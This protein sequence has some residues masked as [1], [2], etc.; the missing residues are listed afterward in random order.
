MF[1]AD[2]S[3]TAIATSLKLYKARR[4]VRSAIAGELIVFNDMLDVGITIA[5]KIKHLYNKTIPIQLFT[6]SK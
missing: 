4:I 3:V 5:G 6:D 2:K 1:L